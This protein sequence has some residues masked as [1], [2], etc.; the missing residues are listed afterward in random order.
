VI[1]LYILFCAIVIVAT[2]QLPDYTNRDISEEHDK[3][4][5]LWGAR[6]R[7]IRLPAVIRSSSNL[8]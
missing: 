4:D 8:S 1:V 2:A 7:P 3:P 5:C 6:S